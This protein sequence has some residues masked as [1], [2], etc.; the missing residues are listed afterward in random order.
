MEKHEAVTYLF[1]EG[2]WFSVTLCE[3]T[4]RV[5]INSDHGNFTS[6]WGSQVNKLKDFLL[7]C[8]T[9]YLMENF[10]RKQ[11]WESGSYY[12]ELDCEAT[13]A[14]IKKQA[15]E[16][17]YDEDE[18]AEFIES[19]Q[20]IETTNP[21]T[22]FSLMASDPTAEELYN[23]DPHCIPFVTGPNPHL[24]LF[25]EKCWPRFIEVLKQELT[26]PVVEN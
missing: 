2:P 20:E 24:V 5:N 7:S 18:I 17:G 1:K 8:N 19:I 13:V 15:E 4:G 23:Y 3:A 22:F 6:C 14:K 25:F 12:S 26:T 9:D 21:G 16:K 11:F 10:G